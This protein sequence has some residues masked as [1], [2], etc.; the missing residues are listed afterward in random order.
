MYSK[1]HT[2]YNLYQKG[3]AINLKFSTASGRKF[4]ISVENTD[5]TVFE[6][7]ELIED[8]EGVPPFYQMIAYNGH[9]IKNSKK[10]S[11]YNIDE[12]SELFFFVLT[13]GGGF[14]LNIAT[15]ENPFRP[16][17]FITMEDQSATIM[18][19]KKKILDK[20]GLP[21][22]QQRLIYM[23]K[24]LEDNRTVSDYNIR[25][26]GVKDKYTREDLVILVIR[27]RG[28]SRY[29]KGGRPRNKQEQGKPETGT[30]AG[31]TTGG[32]P[33]ATPPGDSTVAAAVAQPAV[34]PAAPPTAPTG[35]AT[36]VATAPPAAPVPNPAGQEAVIPLATEAEPATPPA[37]PPIAPPGGPAEHRHQ[38]FQARQYHR[39]NKQVSKFINLKEL[40]G[41]QVRAL[42]AAE[43]GE[44]KTDLLQELD[45]CKRLE[46]VDI[47]SRS[48]D[49]ALLKKVF[50][51]TRGVMV[52]GEVPA[53]DI[54]LKIAEEL[55]WLIPTITPGKL[56]H[57]GHAVEYDE[58]A[59]PDGTGRTIRTVT[60]KYRHSNDADDDETIEDLELSEE[61]FVAVWI[62]YNLV[63]N[64]YKPM[65]IELGWEV[66]DLNFD[67]HRA[68]NNIVARIITQKEMAI[69]N[70]V[71]AFHKRGDDAAAAELQAQKDAVTAKYDAEATAATRE[72][73]ARLDTINE[74]IESISARRIEVDKEL[75][76]IES[77]EAD[78][79]GA[80]KEELADEKSKLVEEKRALE[81]RVRK[82]RGDTGRARQIR[83]NTLS[84]LGRNKD[85]ELVE[86]GKAAKTS[87][88]QRRLAREEENRGIRD[89][90]VAALREFRR[91][92]H[93]DIS[94]TIGNR[95]RN[96]LIRSRRLRERAA[97]R[98]ERNVAAVIAQEAAVTAPT[99]RT[100][101]GKKKRPSKRQRAA[102]RAKAEAEKAIQDATAEIARLDRDQKDGWD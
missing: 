43:P 82:L 9:Q 38:T 12:N 29:Q 1:K 75:V 11:D 24:Q 32:L 47:S 45:G 55:A 3:G 34:Q 22:D 77:R 49:S 30:T 53:R 81:Q 26:G 42:L 62:N 101:S 96:K 23:G 64:G 60:L 66:S 7:K 40:F 92:I 73:Q 67:L 83:D 95:Y 94:S 71:V 85:K 52:R 88:K 37:T 35:A 44:E 41:D 87:K 98:A 78:A 102:L 50:L 28:G 8:K 69:S 48:A 16:R 91:D 19:V 2:K 57:V 86:A 79:S 74:E 31:D 39:D 63:L 70:A 100:S 6:L 13:G 90:K 80:D 27:L 61:E 68:W 17:F 65:N 58:S 25:K 14:T 54:P 99:D 84:T 59:D 72:Y 93:L 21:L 20:E 56:D 15:L 33:P 51:R 10:L 36:V 97:A 5:I 76:K 18:D 4:S 89:A 46:P